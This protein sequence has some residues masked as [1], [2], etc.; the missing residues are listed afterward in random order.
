MHTAPRSSRLAVYV[1]AA[2]SGD[3]H[4]LRPDEGAGS[5]GTTPQPEWHTVQRLA[6]GGA[7]MPMAFSPRQH[8]L[9]AVGRSAPFGVHTL[10]VDAHTGHLSRLGSSPLAGNMVYV[11]TSLDG[12]WLLSA[13]YSEDRIA[14][15]A[16]DADGLAGP[17]LQVLDT[18]KQAHAICPAPDGQH[19]WVSCLGADQLLCYRLG[20]GPLPL[21]AQPVM[22]HQSRAQSGP[23]HLAFHPNG[24]WLFVINEL[25]GSVDGLTLGQGDAP[26]SPLSHARFLPPDQQM[27]PWSAELRISADGQWLFASDRRAA[28]LSALR[29]D[30][31]TGQLTLVD[32][33]PTEALPRSFALSPDGLT[34]FVASQETGRLSIMAFDPDAGR[35]RL[36]SQLACGTS[37]TWVEAIPLPH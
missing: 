16:I 29:I 22:G 15:N 8:R 32:C 7:I 25:D 13:S 17:T 21:S 33:V 6:L 28:T 5:P 2:G 14:V 20:P 11:S 31:G 9:Y 37:P 12:Q 1:S 36:H 26:P 34:L 23:R 10:A 19:V 4:V 30:T 3:I 35:M 24:R 27:A 18:P